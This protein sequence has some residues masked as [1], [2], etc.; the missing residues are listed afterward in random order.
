MALR[1][2]RT[3]SVDPQWGNVVLLVHFDVAGVPADVSDSAH[4]LTLVSTAAVSATQKKF[5][6]S[7]LF[8]SSATGG[9]GR[10]TIGDLLT[11][12][13][14]GA[15]QFTVEAWAYFTTVPAGSALCSVMAK[16]AALGQQGWYLGFVQGSLNLQY[17]TTGTDNP[18]VGAAWTPS[19]NQWYH[20]AADRDAANVLRVYLDGVVKA[21]ATVAATFSPSLTNFVIGNDGSAARSFP[22]YVDEARITKGF[23]RYAGAF[24]PPTAAFPGPGL[25]PAGA[26]VLILCQ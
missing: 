17:S 24:T 2:V 1:T 21:S 20:I 25:P 4:V 18:F 12:F 16:W 26:P 8:V 6:A 19:A 13:N 3:P 14:F 11:D 7:S 15:G 10:V 5:G 23:A 22:G 9:T